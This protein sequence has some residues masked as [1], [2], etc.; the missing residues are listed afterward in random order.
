MFELTGYFVPDA[1]SKYSQA[2]RDL[3]NDKNLRSEKSIKKSLRLNKESDW[4]FVCAAMDIF[5]DS[6]SAIDNFL[7][8]EIDGPTKYWDVGEKYLRL[9][10]LLSAAY[11]QQDSTLELYRLM[12][13][14]G[15][16]DAKAKVS[17]L[18]LRAVRNKLASHSTNHRNEETG[19][20]EAFAPVQRTLS[21]MYCQIASLTLEPPEDVDL[22]NCLNE[23][24]TLILDLMDSIYEKTFN[25]LYKNVSVRLEEYSK[26]LEDLRIAKDGGEVLKAGGVRLVLRGP[27]SEL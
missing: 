4:R 18:K 1:I 26:K 24:C 17:S 14:P 2:F 11:L 9:Y 25:T 27:A 22:K 23:H 6:Q 5:D 13:V 12:N 19:E 8:F 3:I 10:G 20:L 21:G 15:W 16:K 7:R